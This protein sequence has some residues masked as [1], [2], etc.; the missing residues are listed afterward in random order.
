MNKVQTAQG[1]SNANNKFTYE[2]VERFVREESTCRLLSTEYIKANDK[3]VFL[4]ECGETFE[5]TFNRFKFRNKRKCNDCNGVPAYGTEEVKDMY[6]EV[7]LEPLFEEYRS[8]KDRYLCKTEEGYLVEVSLDR[9]RKNKKINIFHISNP[10]SINNVHKYIE[11]NKIESK[12]LST[13]YKGSNID[14][15]EFLCKCGN[16]FEMAWSD[17]RGRSQCCRECGIKRR[18]GKRHYGYNSELTQEERI[19]RRVLSS[20][21]N[22]RKFREAVFKRD[23]YT[24]CICGERAT[25]INAHHLNGYHWFKEGRYD[26]NN[27]VT[28]CEKCHRRFH[29]L[30]GRENNTKE[31]YQEYRASYL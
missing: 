5:T 17:F 10:Y 14:K 7:G 4:C 8:S 13:E 27:G 3:M 31:Q 26:A 22:M 25:T 21:E 16:R 15:M 23:N 28:L 6:R 19:E 2:E 1:K 20:T 24:C 11:V 30:Y 29:D 18:S 12:C 9:L